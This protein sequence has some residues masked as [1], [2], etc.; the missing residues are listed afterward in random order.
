MSDF[1]FYLVD[2]L[3]GSQ[4]YL[5]GSWTRQLEDVYSFEASNNFLYEGSNFK[6]CLNT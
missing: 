1:A 5:I 6:Q 3:I 4:K 2:I